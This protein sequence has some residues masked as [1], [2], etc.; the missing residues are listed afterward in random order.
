MKTSI[1][2]P[3]FNRK[4]YTEKCID[5]IYKYGSDYPFE[6]IV[7]NNASSDGTAEYLR[8][9]GDKAV[10]IN[11]EQNRGFAKAC[12]QGAEKA[13]GEYLLFLNND[14]IVTQNWMD[15]LVSE[16]DENEGVA[17]AGSKLI[18]PDGTIQHAGVVFADDKTPYHIYK[19]DSPEK[20]YTKK[21]R[22]FKAVT[23]A[24]MII[25]RNIFF[26]VGGFDEAYVNGYEDIDL[27]LKVDKAGKSIMYCPESVIYHYESISDGR[28]NKHS[29]NMK[30][31]LDRWSGYVSADYKN[32]MFEDNTLS[33]LE[34]QKM[35][36]EHMRK[37]IEMMRASNFWKMREWCLKLKFAIFSPGKFARKYLSKK[38]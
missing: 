28:L 36:I 3:V 24:C 5:S 16:L 4:E 32:I 34:S 13:K 11:N 22:K 18:F 14:T 12:N 23:A 38:I 27:C 9:L 21:K 26:E 31:F 6:I 2:I 33:Q 7:V 8:N 17:I 1:I 37:E 35:L 20:F 19:H 15:V 25:R 30:L 10:A 29:E